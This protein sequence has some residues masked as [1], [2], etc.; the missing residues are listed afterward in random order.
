MRTGRW[1]LAMMGSVWFGLAA[2][3]VARPPRVA[4]EV[5]RGT[6]DLPGPHNAREPA[7]PSRGPGPGAPGAREG[8]ADP[9]ER[10]RGIRPPW[11][12]NWIP[13]LRQ[14]PHRP[15]RKLTASLSVGRN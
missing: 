1:L 5:P 13:E 9:P 4:A 12:E 15:S 7:L 2:L 14:Q 10:K 8:G 6:S 3:V 11:R